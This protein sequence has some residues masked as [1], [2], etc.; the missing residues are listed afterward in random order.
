MQLLL[1]LMCHY[2][3]VH[4]GGANSTIV[5]PAL[6]DVSA[7][8]LTPRLDLLSTDI[9]IADVGGAACPVLVFLHQEGSYCSVTV[10]MKN[11][12][13]PK[14]VF[15]LGDSGDSKDARDAWEDEVKTVASAV[16]SGYDRAMR[17]HWW[18]VSHSTNL[19]N[20]MGCQLLWSVLYMLNKQ[21]KTFEVEHGSPFED[22]P[23]PLTK[24]QKRKMRKSLE[25]QDR[26]EMSIFHHGTSRFTQ[27][28]LV[29]I[30][31]S[32]QPVLLL[33]KLLT[34]FM[35][36]IQLVPWQLH[37]LIETHGAIEPLV[38]LLASV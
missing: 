27:S 23:P 33:C 30:S 26:S 3:V 12:R 19:T 21:D 18:D 4:N 28:A 34:R 9:T 22:P 10:D 24:K 35:V 20:T 13:N 32:F 6:I 29:D 17:H 7:G 36:D 5:Y 25:K 37:C 2:S 14:A 31:P 11:P 15:T 8:A 38:E 16:Y 1:A